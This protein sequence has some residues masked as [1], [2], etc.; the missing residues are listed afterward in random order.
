MSG[1]VFVILELMKFR[2]ENQ[3]LRVEANSLGGSLSSI[4]DKERNNE[5]LYQPEPDSWQ[6]QDVAIFPF[7][8]R[9]KGKEY[10]HQGKRYSLKNHGLCR[11]Y[12]FELIQLAPEAMTL[13]FVS[14]EETL[15]EYPFTFRF[16]IHYSLNGKCLNVEY[17]VKNEGEE[18][19]PFGI[20]AHPAFDLNGEE[21][22]GKIDTSK[23]AIF[24]KNTAKLTRICF[25]DRGEMVLGEE[26]FG[27]VSSI[28]IDKKLFRTYQTLCVKGDGISD[29]LLKRADGTKVSFHYDNIEYF[30]LWSFPET[31]HFV[32][33]E[34]WMSLPDY[35]D[36]E[37]EITKKKTLLHLPKGETYTFRYSIRI[38][39]E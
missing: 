10:T 24:F 32:A 13:L 14:S 9:L 31:G 15:K 21:I 23:N 16:E 5:I 27:T 26:D 2:I 12:P 37:L 17:I 20:G 36:A 35:A 8:A 30:V 22:A 7:V 19:M 1:W 34:P 29:V 11:Y 38:D 28:D 18:T 4:L 3:Y 6:G 25:D 33:I 39:E